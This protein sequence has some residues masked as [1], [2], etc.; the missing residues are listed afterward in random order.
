VVEVNLDEFEFEEG[1][2]A[3]DGEEEVKEAD[4]E[5]IEDDID[6]SSTSKSSST[7]YVL[8]SCCCAGD[9]SFLGDAA[10]ATGKSIRTGVP[11]TGDEKADF[12]CS[13]FVKEY[14]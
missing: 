10:E 5:V 12:D 14:T 7:T 6:K 3:V 2:H 9:D 8:Q 13:G 11:D 4:A 1:A